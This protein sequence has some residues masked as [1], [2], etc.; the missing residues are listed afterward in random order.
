[1]FSAHAYQKV[2]QG[3]PELAAMPYNGVKAGEPFFNERR[4][5]L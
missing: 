3:L 4:V 1:M 2:E 5:A